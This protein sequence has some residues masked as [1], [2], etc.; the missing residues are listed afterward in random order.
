MKELF[1]PPISKSRKPKAGSNQLSK[2]NYEKAAASE[3]A[4]SKSSPFGWAFSFWGQKTKPKTQP[5]RALMKLPA[6]VSLFLAA[7]KKYLVDTGTLPTHRLI[8]ISRHE[9]HQGLTVIY[10]RLSIN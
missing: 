7:L 8:S 2:M 10:Y 9:T 1:I 6:F 5:N 4:P 3:K